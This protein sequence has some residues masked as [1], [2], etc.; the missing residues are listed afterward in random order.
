MWVEPTLKEF[1][2]FLEMS[3][4]MSDLKSRGQG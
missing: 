1:T 4:V 2:Y 3:D